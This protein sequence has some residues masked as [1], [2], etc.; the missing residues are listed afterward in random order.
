M[1]WISKDKLMPL[2]IKARVRAGRKVKYIKAQDVEKIGGVWIARTATARVMRNDE[3]LSESVIRFTEVAYE[4]PKVADADFT[5]R[6]LE[7]G[8]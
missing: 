2:Q 5:E 3:L 1:M 4:D 8:L 7:K 6:R